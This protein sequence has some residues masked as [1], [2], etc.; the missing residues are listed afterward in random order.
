MKYLRDNLANILTLTNLFLGFAG[1]INVLYHDLVTGAIL[2]IIASVFDFL[3]G[4]VARKLK[5]ISEKGKQLDSLADFVSFGVLPATILHI[6]I[7]K[8]HEN[9][10]YHLYFTDIP[11]VSFL[12]FAY[13]IA[14]ALRLS[15]FN[16]EKPKNYFQGL[17]TPAAA[18]FVASLPL[19][20]RFDLYVIKYNTIYLTDFILN[21]YFLVVVAFVLS[22]LMI[23]KLPMISLK[24]K[25]FRFKD[26]R[27]LYIIGVTFIASFII[28]FYISI[29][30]TVVVYV[31]MSLILKNRFVNQ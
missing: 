14:A 2:L 9:W 17:P 15:R 5:T 29:P 24:T 8:S 1:I 28:L 12:P 23:S 10:L 26:S 31:L 30:F 16:L 18:L 19:I 27:Y 6:L 21:A 11:V 7:L 20:L 4:F 22:F 13:T 25:S 3:D